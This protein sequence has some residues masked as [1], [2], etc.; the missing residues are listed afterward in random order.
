ME[1]GKVCERGM[2]FR[3]LGFPPPE[4]PSSVTLSLLSSLSCL[5]QVCRDN[6]PPDCCLWSFIEGWRGGERKWE[7]ERGRGREG[8]RR[9]EEGREEVGERG[10]GERRIY[11]TLFIATF[12]KP[13]IQTQTDLMYIECVDAHL[14]GGVF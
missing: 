14:R 11:L 7:R 1:I 6:S 10:E 2:G 3:G 13:S 5:C 12:L 4:P 9:E 8:R